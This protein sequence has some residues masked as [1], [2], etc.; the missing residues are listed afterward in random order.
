MSIK[1]DDVTK[2]SGIEKDIPGES[3]GE[4]TTKKPLPDSIDIHDVKLIATADMYHGVLYTVAPKDFK[5]TS[6]L[7]SDIQG[8]DKKYVYLWDDYSSLFK[9]KEDIWKK[10]RV[11]LP[12]KDILGQTVF[13][14][15]GDVYITTSVPSDWLR[16]QP[17]SPTYVE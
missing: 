7:T 17:L 6:D 5:I 16:E 12:S 11:M 1:F 2:E 15:V 13:K 8:F 3:A 10:L 9:F 4:V 14:S